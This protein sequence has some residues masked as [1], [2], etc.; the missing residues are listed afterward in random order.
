ME[1]KPVIYAALLGNLAVAVTKFAAAAVSGSSAMLT[2][3]FHS[4][5][6]TGNGLLLLIGERVSQRPADRGHPFGHGK[7]LYFY[8]VIVAVL[9]F[10]VGGGI[11]IYE[12]ILH[13]IDPRPAANPT[14]NYIVIGI[15]AAFE[16]I[17]WT[18]AITGVLRLRG[19]G[20]SA[21][22]TVRSSK[23]PTMVAVVFEDTAALLGLAVAAAGIYLS[24]RLKMPVFDGVA[25]I[26][27]G[28]LLCVVSLVLLR[29][30]KDLLVGE[31]ASPAVLATIRRIAENERDVA[32]VG[33]LMTMHLGP[34][35]I[36]LNLDLQFQ[37]HLSAAEIA[38]TVRR[39][40][41]RIGKADDR[42][43]H[44]FIEARALADAGAS[45]GAPDTARKEVST[46]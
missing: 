32:R 21:W 23:D 2:E 7:E 25:S 6:D 38:S 19:Q 44:I 9:I 27:I 12:G 30:S 34:E 42:V 37:E 3:G 31:A 20:R 43:K 26:T 16:G 10:G 18:F 33:R 14:M 24:E 29:E 1:R 46:D 41:T 40:E 15:A 5:A 11:S 8:T 35:E 45:S 13:V 4:V 22:Q 17:S 36:L 39:L 28:V